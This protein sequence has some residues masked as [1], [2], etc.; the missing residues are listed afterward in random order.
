MHAH[1]PRRYVSGE[2]PPALPRGAAKP[3]HAAGRR[4]AAWRRRQPALHVPLSRMPPALE[5]PPPQAPPPA[6]P[7]QTF[8]FT[9]LL[10]LS[11]FT[12][13]FFFNFS[14]TTPA[15]QTCWPGSTPPWPQSKSCWSPCLGVTRPRP[16]LRRC[17]PPAAVPWRVVAGRPCRRAPAPAGR[18]AWRAGPTARPPSLSCWT[19]CSSPSAAP[20]RQAGRVLLLLLGAIQL[21]QGHGRHRAMRMPRTPRPGL[22]DCPNP[23]LLLLP[24]AL[25][26][27]AATLGLGEPRQ[28][29]AHRAPATLLLNLSDST[30]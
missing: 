14:R 17:A 8:D 30:F 25:P 3:A 29:A 10:L 28:E 21:R 20:S 5:P 26:H 16:G 6:Q 22:A 18:A 9:H 2:V 7:Q 13:F 1:D 12:R 15:L 24:A 27:A 4:Y 19:K 11:P 23:L